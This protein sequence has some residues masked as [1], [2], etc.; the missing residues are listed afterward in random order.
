LNHF[1]IY[2]VIVGGCPSFF[3]N[4]NIHLGQQIIS[5]FQKDKFNIN[6]SYQNFEDPVTKH[7]FGL[8]QWSQEFSIIIQENYNNEIY[9]FLTNKSIYSQELDPHFHFF[10]NLDEWQQHLSNFDLH[11]GTRIHNSILNVLCGNFTI[12]ITHDDRTKNLCKTLHIPNIPQERFMEISDD[13]NKILKEIHFDAN[14]FDFNRIKLLTIFET[15]IRHYLPNYQSIH[16]DS[17]IIPF[18]E[19]I[20]CNQK[21]Y[22]KDNLY[23]LN[24]DTLKTMLPI[25]FNTHSYLFFNPD[26]KV[27]KDEKELI[28]HYL[29]YGKN[30]NRIY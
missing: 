18:Y 3:L 10:Y 13:L 22:N 4:Q 25:N 30:E 27:F 26:L 11:I 14:L 9:N 5:K 6:V 24:L 12:C 29:L 16:N 28:L 21:L 20:D 19:S 7:L 1:N 17:L 23:L 15:E 8:K 2:N